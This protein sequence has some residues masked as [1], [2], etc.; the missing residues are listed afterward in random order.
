MRAYIFSE[1][2]PAFSSLPAAFGIGSEGTSILT[3]ESSPRSVYHKTLSKTD[4]F[5][6]KFFLKISEA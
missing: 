6:K 3:P 5:T 1:N 4:R 2:I